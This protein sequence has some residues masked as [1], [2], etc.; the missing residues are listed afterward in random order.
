M[1][2]SGLLHSLAGLLVCCSAAFRGYCAS[3]YEPTERGDVFS[4]IDENDCWSD[5][6]GLHQDRHYTHGIKVTFLGGDHAMTNITTR[7]NRIFWWGDQPL[8]GNFGFVAGQDMYTPEN[9]LDPKPI[10][11]DRP[12]AGWLYGGVVY[13]RRNEHSGHYAIMENFE[14]NLGVVGP[15][16]QADDTQTLIHRWRFPEDLPAGWPNQIHN[17]PG[18]EL[19]YARLWRYSLNDDTAR[20]VDVVPRAGFEAGNVALF[21]TAGTALR[22]GFNL[23]PDFGVQIIDSPSSVTGGMKHD[24]P[25]ISAYLFGGVDGRYVVHDITLDGNTFRDSQSVQKND[26]VYDLSW[27]VAVALGR[28]FELS[29]TQVTRSLEFD[30]QQGKDVFGSINFTFKFWF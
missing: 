23:P 28:Y 26:F 15:D 10:L 11:T 13:Q 8:P 20:F 29:W 14:L 2:S 3:P 1:F 19:K 7:L 6:F 4:I 25:L 9:I 24:T 5:P 17:E 22:V 21:G 30:G 12:Y 18:L 27:G 16:S